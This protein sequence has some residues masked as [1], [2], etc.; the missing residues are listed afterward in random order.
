MTNLRRHLSSVPQERIRD[1]QE[2]YLIW[3]VFKQQ[4]TKKSLKDTEIGIMV[5]GFPN[6]MRHMWQPFDP[7][8]ILSLKELKNRNSHFRKSFT[9]VVTKEIMLPIITLYTY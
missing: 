7:L 4:D 5:I 9:Y 8:P 1:D 3:N 6:I 2:L